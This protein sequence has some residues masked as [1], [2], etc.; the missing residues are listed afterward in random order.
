MNQQ[1]CRRSSFGASHD[2]LNEGHGIGEAAAP[3]IVREVVR[4]SGHPLDP[5]MREQMESRFGHDFSQVRLH[6]GDKAA[7]SA[8][9]V[10][11]EAYTFGQHIAFGRGSR[12]QK[13]LTH[14]LTHVVQQ[15]GGTRSVQRKPKEKDPLC[16]T[17]DVAATKKL[18]ATQAAAYE[19]DAKTPQ[20][21]ALIRTLKLIHRCATVEEQTQVRS[22]LKTAVGSAADAL[23]TEAGTPFG[24]YTGLYPSYAPGISRDLK[25]L[26]ASERLSAGAYKTAFK[27]SSVAPTDLVKTHRSRAKSAAKAMVDELDR[28]DVIYFM[29]HHYGRY[30][31]PG[32]FA[33]ASDKP[34][35]NEAAGFD[36]RYIEKTGGFPNVKVLIS[37]SCATL[38]KEPFDI[39]HGLFPNAALLGYRGGAPGDGSAVRKA[40]NARLKTLGPL[41]LDQAVDIG[42]IVSAWKDTVAGIH[43][44]DTDRLPGYY[45]GTLNYW[46]GKAWK[47]IAASA[48]ENPCPVTHDAREQ[49]PAPK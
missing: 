47:T 19:A 13:L 31:A 29:G 38:C 41:L 18:V 28:T 10:D 39:F 17:V 34:A 7:R 5:R 44:G 1:R 45:D 21:H 37:T 35:V 20:R 46:D 40:F 24:G 6:T 11:A 49:L 16:G 8:D 9:A 42:S 4:S 48:P 12:D 15:S 43:A 30:R 26:G 33:V 27:D 23:W 14:E 25:D 36:L 2:A 3:P 22:D 32:V